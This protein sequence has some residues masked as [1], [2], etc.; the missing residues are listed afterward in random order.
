MHSRSRWLD[1]LRELLLSALLAALLFLGTH[2]AIQAREVLGP[3]MQPTYH[4]GERLFID[5]AIYARFN[6]GAVARF[7]PFLPSGSNDS[8]VFHGP[9]RGDVVV[10]K[11]PV[12]SRDDYIKRVIGVSGDHI[13]VRGGDVS[14]NGRVIDEPYIHAATTACAST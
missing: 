4:T 10:F 8:Y 2:S 14:V 11:P 5:R 9:Q 1:L 6:F 13:L 7:I 3:S 12:P